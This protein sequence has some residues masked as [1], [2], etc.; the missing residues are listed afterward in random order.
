MTIETI[1]TKRKA[2]YKGEVGLFATS[3]MAEEDL[4]PFSMNDDVMA[5]ISSERQ[6]KALRKLWGFVYKGYQNTDYWLNKDK[7][8]NYFKVKAG[9]VKP[10]RDPETGEWDMLLPKS[11]TRISDNELRLLTDRVV[12]IICIEVLPGVKQVDLRREIEE[13]I[14]PRER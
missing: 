5:K 3:E 14:K 12:D 1:L 9:H 2:L 8:M 10:G 4:A 7:A 11:L 6:M 13:M